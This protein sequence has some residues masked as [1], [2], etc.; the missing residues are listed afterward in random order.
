MTTD[1][2]SDFAGFVARA[3]GGQAP[4]PYQQRIA[5]E[6]PPQLLAVPTGAGKTLAAVLPWLYRRR[7]GSEEVRKDT[8]PW[9]VFVLPMR[10][11]VEQTRD[12]VQSWLSK[13]GLDE[14]VE[15]H[16]LLG[17][18]PRTARWRERVGMD[19]IIVGTLDMILSRAL[20]R[21][22]GE[23]RFLWPIDF[24]LLNAGCHFVF[25]E[26]QLMGPA[27]ATSRQ[28]HG[29]RASLGTVFPC[30]ST[31]MSATV[32]EAKLETVDA[33]NIS[34]RIELSDDDL[35]GPLKDRAAASKLV[36]QLMVEADAKYFDCLAANLIEQH[37]QGTLSLA[38][39]NTVERA[40]EVATA[41]RAYAPT[42]DVVLLHS[43]FRPPERQQHVQQMLSPIDASG[44]GRIVVSTQVIEAG[45]DVSA[46][47][48]LTEVAPWPSVVQRAGRC[49]RDGR[50]E[51]AR[52]VWVDPPAAAPY[53]PADLDAS[54]AELTR[55]EGQRATP[56]DLRAIRLE[57][58]EEIQPVLRRRDLLDLFDTMPDISGNDIDV[59]RF[60]RNTEDIDVAVAW[61]RV[62][63]DGP[64]ATDTLPGRDERCPVPVGEVRKAL[65][66]GKDAWTYEHLT[67]RFVSVV[68]ADIRPGMVI[69]LNTA[70]GMYTP[71]SGWQPSSRTEV[72]SIVTAPAV[73]DLAI[74]DDPA[75]AMGSWVS[76][77][78]HL[79]DTEQAA[80]R[81]L[82]RVSSW[83]ID[84]ALSAA[85]V[86]A[87]ALHDVGKAHPVFQRSVRRLV[88]A[89]GG[90]PPS[91]DVVLA[92]SG[93][94]GRLRHER[95]FFR[96]ELSSALA[97]LGEGA[98]AIADVR[99]PNLVVYLVGAHHGRVRMGLRPMPGEQPVDGHVVALG[100]VDGESLPAVALPEG[101]I[102]ATVLDLSV[103][104]MGEQNGCPSWS[105]RALSLRDRPDV[106]PFRLGFLEAIVR[107]ADWEASQLE[108]TGVKPDG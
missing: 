88:P 106:G 8:P 78:Q 27:L 69:V 21:G 3:T 24:G 13:L 46:H 38:V 41:L 19:T 15:C 65:K 80:T 90:T 76:L 7:F 64:A 100:I 75:S 54:R 23:S 17:G 62:G 56:V 4:Y 37:R 97:L 68:A 29:L 49:N 6:G 70:A 103:M 34:S 52:L 20:N 51:S 72:Q 79:D 99:E 25:D 71:V 31:W 105:R 96:H 57:V 61:R 94:K 42:A 77:A 87:A 59:A 92:K 73:D 89:G 44:P 66:A 12:A 55:L 107:L 16:S 91:D 43:R 1:S 10:V 22:Y 82:D 26:V 11:L 93:G 60:I 63:S 108:A 53:A 2:G 98:C 45:V 39:L 5:I 28:L 47:L 50:A 32:P 104:A 95:R 14:Q 18:E 67:A 9:L 36:C 84:E 30:S 86:R 81:L 74:G 48:L 102:P 40:R 85:A 35:F 33:P 58:T 83:G 101:E